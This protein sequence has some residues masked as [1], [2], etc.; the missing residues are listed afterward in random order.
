MRLIILLFA[1]SFGT[2]ANGSG[3]PEGN[4]NCDIHAKGK[5]KSG[6]LVFSVK[7]DEVAC[8]AGDGQPGSEDFICQEWFKISSE[9]F[10][11]D[12]LYD[13]GYEF[14]NEGDFEV[15]ADS[16]GCNIGELV[17]YKNS[18]FTKGFITTEF[19]CSSNRT[20]RSAGSVS[21]VIK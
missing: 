19:R 16:D 3:M 13:G 18:G 5:A 1:A 2:L 6:K 8:V 15:F 9:D 11:L 14:N 10:W 12:G 20:L 4:Y 21:C 7:A 17:L